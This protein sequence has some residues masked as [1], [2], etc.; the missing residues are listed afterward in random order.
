MTFMTDESS[1]PPRRRQSSPEAL[2]G[3]EAASLVRDLN[4]RLGSWQAVSVKLHTISQRLRASG[5]EDPSVV[6]DAEALLNAVST[7]A[8]RFE[9]L[10]AEQDE[11]VASHARVEDTRRSFNMIINRLRTTLASLGRGPIVDFT[12]V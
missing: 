10:V 9:E 4:R 12:A 8:Q 1:E 5:R 2:A 6:E 3:R 7:E 11:A